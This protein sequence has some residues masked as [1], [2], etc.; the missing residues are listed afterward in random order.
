MDFFIIFTPFF[1][2]DLYIYTFVVGLKLQTGYG[3]PYVEN[4]RC[5]K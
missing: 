3:F 1:F 2:L 5:F 4:W